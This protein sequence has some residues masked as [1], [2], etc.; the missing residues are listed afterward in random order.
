MHISSGEPSMVPHFAPKLYLLLQETNGFDTRQF[1]SHKKTAKYR[2]KSRM[3]S[4]RKGRT[5]LDLPWI[6]PVSPDFP[7]LEAAMAGDC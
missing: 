2:S 4:L 6:P 3:I 1:H 5:R 7:V